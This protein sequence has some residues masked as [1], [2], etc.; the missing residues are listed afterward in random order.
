MSQRNIH[1]PHFTAASRG[2]RAVAMTHAMV[3][4][5]R[6]D[7]AIVDAALAALVL[8][9]VVLITSPTGAG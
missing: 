8:V 3:P 4:R 1:H 6:L 9:V 7:L 5:K 2:A